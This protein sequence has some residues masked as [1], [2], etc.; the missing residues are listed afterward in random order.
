[1]SAEDNWITVA[2]RDTLEPGSVTGVKAGD[3][4][5]ALYNIDGE[6]F[7]TDNICTHA[8]AVLSDGWLEGDVIECPLHAGGLKSKPERDLVRP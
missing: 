3:F 7:A 2:P 8:Q 4:D 5:I 1:M 6:I